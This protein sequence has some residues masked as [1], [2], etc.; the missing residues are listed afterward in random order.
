M[1]RTRFRATWDRVS[2][3]LT[4]T[5]SLEAV[6]PMTLLLVLFP[7]A[8]WL[9]YVIVAVAGG[10][11]AMKR[12]R[13]LPW[14]W[15]ALAGLRGT[16]H[17]LGGW[18]LVDNHHYLLTYWCGALGLVLLSS[19]PHEVLRTN[20][21][22]LLGLCFAFAA[23]WKVVGGEYLDGSFPAY[24]LLTDP[25]ASALIPGLNVPADVLGANHEALLTQLSYEDFGRSVRLQG[26]TSVVFAAAVFIGLWT[27]VIEAL[28]AL[29]FLLPFRGRW[30]WI[31]DGSLL[32]FVA[33]TYVFA[34]VLVFGGLLLSMGYA[35]T[36]STDT[37]RRLAYLLG[38]LI[39]PPVVY[40]VAGEAARGMLFLGAVFLL[41]YLYR[42]GRWS[43][44]SGF[45][46][47]GL[48]PSLLDVGLPQAMVQGLLGVGSAILAIVVVDLLS[49]RRTAHWIRLTGVSILAIGSV[50]AIVALPTEKALPFVMWGAAAGSVILPLGRFQA[51]RHREPSP[52]A[53]GNSGEGGEDLV[54]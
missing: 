38:F 14:L 12:L 11:L 9:Y 10:G 4:T 43:L 37:G 2:R 51:R 31:G 47:L 52:G 17:V 44:L 26:A 49:H 54:R 21:R 35:Q 33:T 19:K 42:W 23:L 34:P 8:T 25:H 53:G 30:R 32:V 18:F 29:G 27:I 1:G 15:L 48:A 6:L 41:A 13:T 50:V 24:L 16:D 7:G 22:F 20:A 36:R 46:A 3:H 45:I 5:S 40:A 39:L 28:I